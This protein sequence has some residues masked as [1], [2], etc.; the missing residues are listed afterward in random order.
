MTLETWCFVPPSWPVMSTTR[1]FF[2]Y[3][4]CVLICCILNNTPHLYVSSA[5]GHRLSPGS[6]VCEPA[7]GWEGGS[8]SPPAPL[9]TPGPVEHQRDHLWGKLHGGELLNLHYVISSTLILWLIKIKTQD[10]VER[11]QNSYFVL[12]QWD[13]TFVSVEGLRWDKFEISKDVG[14]VV[15]PA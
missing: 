3:D 4:F 14:N 13:W 2:S 15:L 10:E 9:L 5:E 8:V 12:K 1:L 7:G 6:L 11:V